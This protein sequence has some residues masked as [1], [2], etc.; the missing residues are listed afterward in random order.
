MGRIFT[1]I[2]V[3]LLCVCVCEALLITLFLGLYCYLIKF[4]PSSFFRL[5]FFLRLRG[6]SEYKNNGNQTCNALFNCLSHCLIHTKMRVRHC[7][8]TTV[9]TQRLLL[10]YLLTLRNIQGHLPI[11]YWPYFQYIF[12][13]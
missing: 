8:T 4:F 7:T 2:N 9:V 3:I 13:P 12:V 6:V 11:I 5:R 1:Y 10:M